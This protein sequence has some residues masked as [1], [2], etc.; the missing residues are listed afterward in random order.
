MTLCCENVVFLRKIV[1]PRR[2]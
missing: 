1:G 2:H